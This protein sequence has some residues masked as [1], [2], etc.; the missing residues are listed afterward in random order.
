MRV[1]DVVAFAPGRV[2][3]IGD[4]TDHTGGWCL[5]IALDRGVTVRG[6][7]A[8][9]SV[10][11]HSDHDE[12]PAVVSV[13]VSDPRSVTPVWARYVAGVVAQV[14]PT[15]GLRGTVSSDL[16]IGAGLS[17]S[18][19]LEVAVALALGV[20]GTALDIALLCQRAEQEAS[21]V[22]C[23]ILDQLASTSGVEGH[24]LLMD[25]SEQTTTPVPVPDDL[26]FVVVHSGQTR[27]LATSE[28]ARRRE[29]CERAEEIIGPL[30]SATLDDLA[31]LAD[32]TLRR[33][34]H[35]VITEN[36]RVWEVAAAF[37]ASDAGTVGDIFS[38]SHASLRE[39]F[40]CSTPAVDATVERLAA[41]P[42]VHGARMSG[43]GWG[44]CVVAAAER[45]ALDEG[46]VVRPGGPARTRAGDASPPRTPP[47]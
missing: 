1:D 12:V 40:E 36:A 17:S 28:Y 6:E 13:D 19:A 35:H 45:G 26:E 31:A 25:C 5:P 37:A 9:T 16:P 4:H 47:G 18:A 14:R 20:R 39:D 23:G 8:G 32:E 3:L 44:G 27:S 33:R 22:P 11:L 2:N 43:G 38:A 10:E 41:T 24:A 29:E 7:R 42:G 30:R 21:G 46:W 34:A 15:V